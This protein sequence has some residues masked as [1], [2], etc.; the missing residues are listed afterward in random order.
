MVTGSYIDVAASHPLS[1]IS[2]MMLG[3]VLMLSV[4]WDFRTYRIP[5]R[6]IGIG[7]LAGIVSSVLLKGWNGLGEAVLGSM[8][9]FFL[10]F[11]LYRL[12]SLGAGDIKLF[13]VVGSF[14]GYH[15]LSIILYSFL[16]GGILAVI[17]I[18][19]CHMKIIQLKKEQEK[20]MHFSL[21]IALGSC[22][23]WL[24]EVVAG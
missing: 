24:Q 23:Y 22:W 4:I 2:K 8:I 20:V 1:L 18:L 12:H 10:L 17:R 9:P 14:T 5:N 3:T 7:F 13:C 15:I 11:L 19:C 16:A 6:F 21:A